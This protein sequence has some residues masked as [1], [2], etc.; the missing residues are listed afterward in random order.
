MFQR[1]DL[2]NQSKVGGKD[3]NQT[4]KTV[5]ITATV[6]ALPAGQ[7]HIFLKGSLSDCP[8]LFPHK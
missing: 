3:L 4:T 6:R 5:S 7:E 8:Q 1:L 2:P